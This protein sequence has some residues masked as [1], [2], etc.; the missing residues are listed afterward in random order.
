MN[1]RDLEYLVALADHRHFGRA[2]AASHV[3]Q[4]TLSTQLKKLEGELGVSLIER[5][6]RQVLLTAAGEQIVDRARRILAQV[7]DIRGLAE[8]A[9][10]PR[11][12]LLRLGLFPT[13]GPYL[14]PHVVEPLRRTFPRLRLH[15]VEEQSEL[16][17]D[18]LREGR[19]DAALL[20]M[21]SSDPTLH[22][23]AVFREDF[24]AALP[25]EH[26]LAEAAGPL[27]HDALNDEGLLLLAEGHCLRQDALAACGGLDAGHLGRRSAGLLADDEPSRLSAFEATSLETLRHMVGSGVGV[28]LMPRLAVTDPV[29]P[30]PG[31]V[32]REFAAPPPSRTIGLHWRA[33]SIYHHLL[34]EVAAVFRQLPAD[35]VTP[36]AG[37]AATG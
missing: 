23:E 20:S 24:V 25:A 30:A 9:Q 3:S 19:L 8:Q 7:G 10:D 26:P 11:A 6:S 12:G 36:V 16:L 1:L 32:L 33:T 37:G 2:A 22:A 18:R 5:G 27:A 34:P 4:P 14:L 35:L 13:L 15:L 17:V 28:T 29:Q 21:P 31:I